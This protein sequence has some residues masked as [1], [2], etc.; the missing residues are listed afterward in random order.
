[1]IPGQWSEE[2]LNMYVDMHTLTGGIVC[3]F[4]KQHSEAEE[5]LIIILSSTL[6][7]VGDDSHGFSNLFLFSC[8][9]Q[10]ILFSAPQDK[11]YCEIQ[12]LSHALW[13]VYNVSSQSNRQCGKNSLYTQSPGT[14]SP[15]PG[16][17][18]WK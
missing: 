5:N 15:G 1:M 17:S 2:S 4:I 11:I 12:R 13:N 8:H 7:S 6:I 3:N 10:M 9:S 16:L 14:S 18:V